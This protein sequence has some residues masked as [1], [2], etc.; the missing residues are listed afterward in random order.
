MHIGNLRTALY[1]WLFARHNNGDFILR[2]ED[3]DRNRLVEEASDVIFNTLKDT[4]LNYDE[5]PDV[6][7]DYGPYVQSERKEIYGKY[8]K[9]LV[10]K[11]AAYYCF[12]SKERLDTLREEAQK[13]GKVFKY[14][15]HCLSLSKEEVQA[16][17]DAGEEYVIRQNIPLEGE[18][19]YD[20][21]VYGHISVPMSDMEDNILLKSDGWP[22]YNLANVIDD[23]L[24]EVTHV[25]RGIEYLSSTPKY[26][27]LYDAFGWERPQYVHLPP[28]MKDKTAKLSKRNGDASY[29]DLIAKGYLKEAIINYIALLGWN[30]KDS[31]QEFFTMDELK[32]SFSMEGLSKSPAVFDYEKLKWFN[33]EYIKKMD[34]ESYNAVALPILD[35]LCQDYVDTEKLAALLHTRISAF[36]EIEE[37]VGFV[38]ERLPMDLSLYRNKRNK[39]NP[40]NSREMLKEYLPVLKKC[41]NW[42]NDSLF[43]ISKEYASSSGRKIG[44]VMWAVRIAVARQRITPGGATELM[45]VFGREESIERIEFAINELEEN[46]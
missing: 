24:M 25:I 13:E 26:N 21:L 46:C 12:C 11:G 17:L 35:G 32:E 19:S 20:D 16:K 2:I 10:D 41:K 36:G 44:A 31:T 27:L 14:D 6:G 1:A 39:T 43:E 15:K 18:S 8:A 4:G 38:V 5:G 37:Q 9:A 7:G 3:T 23:H 42:D 33:S 34:E 40:E 30:P 22:T 28:V 29:E 45:E